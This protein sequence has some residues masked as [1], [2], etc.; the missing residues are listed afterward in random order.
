LGFTLVLDPSAAYGFDVQRT[1]PSRYWLG[2]K[3]KQLDRALLTD[4]LTAPVHALQDQ[5][6]GLGEVVASA[7]QAPLCLGQRE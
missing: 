1:L 2:H 7:R 6:P 5:I 4:L 3:L